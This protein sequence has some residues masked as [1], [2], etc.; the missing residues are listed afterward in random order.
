M[1]IKNKKGHWICSYCKKEYDQ[2]TDADT[3]RESHNL[4][5]IALA[6]D[7]LNRLIQYIFTKDE[8]LLNRRE[9]IVIT[10]QEALKNSIKFDKE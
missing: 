8:R 9:R 4:V 5:Y 1:A 3:C 10:L 2:A 6:Q 7:D